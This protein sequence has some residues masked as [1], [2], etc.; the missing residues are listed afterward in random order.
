MKRQLVLKLV[1]YLF[2]FCGLGLFTV[3]LIRE[4][5]ED[6]GGALAAAGWGVAAIVVFHLILPVVG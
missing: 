5:V 3:L 2:A 6:V 4:G 1:A